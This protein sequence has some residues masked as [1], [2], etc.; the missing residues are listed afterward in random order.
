MFTLE[1]AP[2]SIEH[3]DVLKSFL[4]SGEEQLTILREYVE[5]QLFLHFH[6]ETPSRAAV[7]R[8]PFLS[9]IQQFIDDYVA[10]LSVQKI[11][12]GSI[13]LCCNMTLAEK[14]GLPAN[15][16]LLVE[17]GDDVLKPV[18]IFRRAIITE[19]DRMLSVQAESILSRM[20]TA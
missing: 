10:C 4:A 1:F 2:N 13:A 14:K 15:I 16:V 17:Y 8:Y 12:N 11:G 5:E 19:Q 9:N 3:K 7:L 18:S 6:S 20:A